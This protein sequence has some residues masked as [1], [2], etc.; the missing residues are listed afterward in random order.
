MF[1]NYSES[2]FLVS[3]SEDHTIR[4][5]DLST[6]KTIRIFEGHQSPVRK[7]IISPDENG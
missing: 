1:F 7:V 3:G 4:L 5:W 2:G 6:G